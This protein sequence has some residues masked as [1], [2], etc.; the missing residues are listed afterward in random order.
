MQWNS[1]NIDGHKKLYNFWD[2]L[3]FTPG[4]HVDLFFVQGFRFFELP[5]KFGFC[6]LRPFVSS[7]SICHPSVISVINKI[8][9]LDFGIEILQLLLGHSLP[10]STLTRSS[11]VHPIILSPIPA[12]RNWSFEIKL[13][14]WQV[15]LAFS[16][17]LFLD[18]LLRPS[19][20]N[21]A[22]WF[23]RELNLWE[24]QHC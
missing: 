22:E 11:Q 5:E 7:Q 2:F 24:Q 15:S 17:D 18:P 6:G 9:Y 19:S 3:K 20:K 12:M 8:T 13:E 4:L 14:T 16:N 23:E 10:L 21:S 1:K